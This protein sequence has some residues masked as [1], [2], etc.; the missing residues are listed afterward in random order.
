MGGRYLRAA[1]PDSDLAHLGLCIPLRSRSPYSIKADYDCS[2]KHRRREINERQPDSKV[3]ISFCRAIEITQHEIQLSRPGPP[4]EIRSQGRAPGISLSLSDQ[5]VSDPAMDPLLELSALRA[6]NKRSLAEWAVRMD[7][8]QYP[9]EVQSAVVRPLW[10]LAS[11]RTTILKSLPRKASQVANVA[12][13]LGYGH[14]SLKLNF[15]LK[16]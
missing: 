15:S 13:F 7:Q 16:R 1:A 14:F 5:R 9:A 12:I 2:G 3:L 11:W 4:R 8:W 10:F 6:S